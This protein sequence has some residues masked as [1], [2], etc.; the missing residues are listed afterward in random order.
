MVT[1][2]SPAC[3]LGLYSHLSRCPRLYL[4]RIPNILAG[5][6][7]SKDTGTRG[8]NHSVEICIGWPQ[9]LYSLIA[10]LE[11]RCQRVLCSS[12]VLG[13]C[14]SESR[15]EPPEVDVLAD[16]KLRAVRL[17]G[18]SQLIHPPRVGRWLSQAF[19]CFLIL[20]H[21][22]QIFPISSTDFDS[23]DTVGETQAPWHMG[24]TQCLQ[25][26]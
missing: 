20:A 6:A 18:Y 10:L 17:Q 8:S 5:H 2:H 11:C 9:S 3:G 12:E 14:Q 22:H 13:F 16:L 21:Q 7:S 25:V 15:R 4:P 26:A 24:I 19:C 1:F 23:R